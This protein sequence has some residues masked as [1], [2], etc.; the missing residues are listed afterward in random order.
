MRSKELC[1]V[2]ENHATVKPDS[3]VASCG[4]KTYSESRNE[5]RNLKNLE[6]NA[7][8]SSQFLSAEP[9]SCESKSLNAAFKI[10]GVEEILSENLGLRS[11]WRP[12]DSIFELKERN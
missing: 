5:Q 3:S 9:Y 8:M 4:M 1:S 10:A 2:E 12:F 11:T 7:E 6:E